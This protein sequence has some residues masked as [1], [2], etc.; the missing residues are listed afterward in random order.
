METS[1]NLSYSQSAWQVA[2]D[3]GGASCLDASQAA[4]SYGSTVGTH[5]RRGMELNT[6]DL[7]KHSGTDV[8]NN[9]PGRA[10]P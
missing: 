3:V 9:V 7:F 4:E 1:L 10:L 8:G 5:R 6:A 2:R